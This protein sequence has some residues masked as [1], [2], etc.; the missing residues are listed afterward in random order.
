MGLRTILL[1]GILVAS[2]SICAGQAHEGIHFSHLSADQG[3]SQNA[4]L[5]IWQDKEGF[6]WLG[7]RDGLNKYDGYS[8]TVYKP[9][10]SDPAN[11]FS[12]N[13]ITDICED[14]AGRMWVS[15]LGGGLHLFDRRSG[16]ATA[17]RIINP[18]RI[19]LRNVMY[20]IEE[21]HEGMLWIASR[22]GLTRFDPN[23]RT[24]TLY[25][26][27]NAARPDVYT[28][29]EDKRGQLWVGT[30]DGLYR[31]DP[32]SKTSQNVALPVTSA[33][34]NRSISTLLAEPSGTIWVES[35]A[36]Q[37]YRIGAEGKPVR[38]SLPQPEQ[39][40]QRVTSLTGALLKDRAGQ[41]WTAPPGLNRLIRFNP[42]THQWVQFQADQLRPGSLSSHSIYALFQDREG[43][44]WV[45]TNNGV[46]KLSPTPDK[47]RS[48]QIIPNT[49]HVRLPQNSIRAIAQDH[50][51]RIWLANESDGLVS[52]QPS[53]GLYRVYPAN[54]AVANQLYSQTVNALWCDHTGRVWIG[55]GP[56]LH[57]YDPKTDRFVRYPCAISVRS[58]REGV[59][60]E[61]WIA[62]TGLARFDTQ[63]HRFTYYHHDPK[64]PASLGDE[65]LILALPTQDGTVWAAS[66]RRGISRLTI[67]TG[68]FEQY[69][70]D[71]R[72][73]TNS[74]ND[75]DI[76]C[77]YQDRSSRIWIGTNQG[78]L[79]LY[80]PVTNTFRAFTTHDGLPGNHIA[81]ILDD[82]AGNLWL[83]TNQG[84]CRFNPQTGLCQNYDKSDGLQGNEFFEAYAQGIHHELLMGGANGFSIFSPRSVQTNT[85]IPPVYITK[86][87]IGSRTES[88]PQRSLVLS[89]N[90]NYLS[91]DFLALNYIHPEKNKYA[92]QL[93]G[94]DRN[95]IFCG[96]RR[97]VSYAN[98]PPGTYQFRV[99]A[100]NNDGVWNQAGTSLGITINPPFWQTNWFVLLLC[101]GVA[102]ALYLGFRYR[103]RQI[104]REESQ[105]TEV[106][107]KMAEMEMQALR[108]Q[109]NPHFIFNS[110]NSI[111]RFIMK[112]ESESASA[113][114][115]KF[116]KL[117]RLI[118]NRSTAEL[119]TL[120]SEL[121][122][123]S[124]YLELE[125]LRFSGRFTF[126]IQVD[127]AIESAYTEIPPMLI[128]PYV[129]NAIWHGLMQKEAGGHI[130]IRIQQQGKQ[131]VCTVEDNGV[132]RQRAAELK[133]KSATH[134]K[135]RGMQITVDRL[136]L[137]QTLYG[138]QPTVTIHD[139]VDALGEPAGTRVVLTIPLL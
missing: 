101:G 32:V 85:R 113:Y 98:L 127:P 74:L 120:E 71:Y 77:I 65:G 31:F 66:T 6:L 111:N 19:S 4:V 116:S 106:N 61:L 47:F 129:E 119:V 91:F 95:W 41:I 44:V 92:Y 121:D 33:D 43:I 54:P 84:I 107:K 104:K 134:T 35:F 5:C 12:H 37:L 21:D 96:T 124:L 83:A 131:L 136:K 79:N 138:Q 68:R 11:T 2:V 73:S 27:F 64:N 24:F 56:Y 114:L 100:S 3:L 28:I 133:S 57:L 40:P 75:K 51:G 88:L 36:G 128:Q 82:E 90:D 139:L 109:M 52:F 76:R 34:T 55:A 42:A 45:G 53:T 89:H 99:K 72:R 86:V 22:E 9:D 123:L 94:V 69:Q 117:I 29:Q 63:T 135:S 60:G 46:D 15:T 132:G 80:N 118:L 70:P 10:P 108:A 26:S 62:G 110:L 14:R 103:V 39:A 137:S 102:G 50:S 97:F 13:V 115:S 7:T 17:Y 18:E 126:A 48:F 112:N 122:T 78:G 130:L 1:L 67:K 38:C 59:G 23:S 49:S 81:G 25:D 58:I 93:V 125:S 87:Q 16:K 105:K 30:Q 8:F 20:A